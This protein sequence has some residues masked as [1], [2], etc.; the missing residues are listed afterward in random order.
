MNQNETYEQ[1]L[2]EQETVIE[3]EINEEDSA[4]NFAGSVFKFSISTFLNMGL[5]AL[6]FLLT[7]FFLSASS[8]GE[9]NTFLNYTN[10]FMT[11]AILGFDQA[12]LR[13]YHNPPAKLKSNALFRH[14]LYFSFSLLLIIALTCSTLF[15][16]PLYKF[17]GFQHVGKWVIPLLFLNAGFYM[18]ARYINL[19]L[20][21]E[22][23]ILAYTIQS[24]LM[25]VFYKLFY[26]IGAAY[27]KNPETA[28]ILCS[29]IGLGGFAIALIIIYFKIIKPRKHELRK[30]AYK[31]L[32]PFGIATAPS[33]V[34]TTLNG[35]LPL[36][37]IMWLSLGA[38]ERG[39]YS[40]GVQLSNIVAMVQGGFSTF[41][42]PYVYKN[43]KTHVRKITYMHD[44]VNFV[45]FVFFCFLVAFEDIIFLILYNFSYVQIIFPIMMLSAIF[46]ILCETTVVGN[47]LM[48][49]PIFDTI[50]I[51][52]GVGVNVLGCFLLIP[53]FGIF[54]AAIA[55][56]AGNAA[57][58]LFRTICGQRLYRTI[59]N[60]FKT[61]G[62]F[63]I[64]IA[65]TV[66]GTYY[67]E[68]FWL[69]LAF[70]MVGVIVYCLLYQQEFQRAIKLGISIIQ[71][72]FKPKRKT[73]KK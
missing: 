2:N 31:E 22:M 32:L 14:C 46:N 67:S 53:P 27:T 5:Y 61:F 65:I 17:I 25:Q 50:G 37:I 1:A 36:S 69:K 38:V 29:A 52:I 55:L 19:M 47:A 24:F 73:N 15:I 13:F 44:F 35:T 51:G 18:I 30:K 56:V 28:M 6:V 59:R 23:R 48:R 49:R 62:A 68:N 9:L 64:A 72:I 57:A 66:A 71:S 21:M 12:F 45:I 39:M 43:Y 7:N 26:L 8:V 4:E 34:F 58:F 40:Y 11:I 60:P 63:A 20:R 10:T 33:A 3:K 41:W 42:I 70:S 16:N 54:G